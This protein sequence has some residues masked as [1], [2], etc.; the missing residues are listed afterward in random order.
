MNNFRITSRNIKYTNRIR[1]VS[2]SSLNKLYL[3]KPII[4]YTNCDVEK[5]NIF[6]FLLQLDIMPI[7]A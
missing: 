6:T 7:K 5:S 2:T 1:L 4:S 3:I